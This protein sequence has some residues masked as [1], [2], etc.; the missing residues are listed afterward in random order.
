MVA[1]GAAVALAVI[2]GLCVAI[3]P[4]AVPT[5]LLTC[6]AFNLVIG[7]TEA[8]WRL[9]GWREP[10]AD[11]Q[12]AWPDPVQPGDEKLAFDLIVPLRDEANVI[13]ET[14]RGLLRQTH[15]RLH[16]VVSLC[17]DDKPT[18][19]AV[20]AVVSE[21]LLANQITI[22]T[23]HY[24]NPTKAQQLNRALKV[25]MG[26]V[27]GVIDA[28]DDV[29]EDLLVHAEA[30]M[31]RDDADVVQGGVQLMNL[32]IGLDKW[33]QVHNV[34]EYFFWFTSRMAFHAATGFVP[35]GGNTVFVR[36]E[37]L[38]RAGGW[39]LSI[40]EDCAL[41]VRLTAE[42]GAKVA[43]AYSAS[44][45]TRE[46]APPSIFNKE[47]GSLFWQRDRWV[48]GFIEQFVAGRW[49]GMPTMK[50]R[51]LAG[52]ILATP[53]LQAI[54][55]VLLPTAIIIGLM[56]NTPIALALL[57]FTPYIPIGLTTAT[58]LI[59]LHDFCRRYEK[60]ASVWHYASLVFLAPLYQIVLCGAA[61]VAVYKYASGDKT[62]YKT[63][64]ASEHR[65]TPAPRPPTPTPPAPTPSTQTPTTATP[66]APAPASPASTTQTPDAEEV[67]DVAA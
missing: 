1:L 32:G 63:G 58:Q 18:I 9:Y 3:A 41:G 39:P 38:E 21:N 66:T 65:G 42:F 64:R 25:C 54:S 14:L 45:T 8:R 12:I 50:Q 52:Y 2:V 49:L 44:L 13:G 7:A 26:D 60:R 15:P 53:I 4:P 27:V 36:R 51:L 37:L 46:E 31:T 30:L 24:A 40:T 56:V 16:I 47:V 29:A 57:L 61:A 67:E 5:F 48:R 35:L 55:F 43:T 34:L 6:T 28:E 11:E 17:D 22:V 10:G 59:G 33:F 62:W 20:R 23:G 19:E